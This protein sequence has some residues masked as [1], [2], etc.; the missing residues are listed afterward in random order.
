MPGRDW[1]ADWAWVNN[2]DLCLSEQVREMLM[3]WLQKI[4]E[5]AAEISDLHD[6]VEK[7]E[8]ENHKLRAVAE[9]AREYLNYSYPWPGEEKDP[10]RA[11]VA[12]RGRLI[13]ALA[14]LDGGR[15][16][17]EQNE[18]AGLAGGLETK[19]SSAMKWCCGGAWTAIDCTSSMNTATGTGN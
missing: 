3:Y 9:A 8:E 17:V 16:E 5:Y 1:Q 11:Y 7:L 2:P 6:D 10:V 15:K 12:I 14:A 13:K 4:M 19:C 18:R